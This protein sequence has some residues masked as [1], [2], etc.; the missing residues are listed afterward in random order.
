MYP[1]DSPLRLSRTLLA[2]L[3]LLLPRCLLGDV[4]PE[5]F[6]TD[7][8]ATL[9]LL[10][11]T[12]ATLPLRPDIP[13]QSLGLAGGGDCL[14]LRDASLSV[15]DDPGCLGVELTAQLKIGDGNRLSKTFTVLA[16]PFDRIEASDPSLVIKNA[17][18]SKIPLVGRRK[19]GPP[20]KL[21]QF[22]SH[23]GPL[24]ERYSVVDGKVLYRIDAEAYRGI[25]TQRFEVTA[26]G[27][28][29]SFSIDL[30][31]NIQELKRGGDAK[32]AQGGLYAVGPLLSALDWKGRP[33]PDFWKAYQ[34]KCSSDARGA[35]EE[36]TG[37]QQLTVAPHAT[38]LV[39]TCRVGALPDLA[40]V[41]IAF[42]VEQV[43]ASI[44][45]EPNLSTLDLAPGKNALVRARLSDASSGSFDFSLIGP[46]SGVTLTPASDS[47]VLSA[48]R[49]P[50]TAGVE[51]PS[52]SVY[53][54]VSERSGRAKPV[55]LEV[56]LLPPI[57]GLKPVTIQID[58]MDDLT[59]SQL[60]GRPASDA[61][62]VGNVAITYNP[63]SEEN[64]ER[65]IQEDLMSSSAVVFSGSLK[66]GV[67][68]EKTWDRKRRSRKPVDF[69]GEDGEWIDTTVED[70]ALL[71]GSIAGPPDKARQGASAAAAP[72]PC[73]AALRFKP[74]SFESI[75]NTHDERD[76]TTTRSRVFKGLSLLGTAA[77][78][79]TSVAVPGPTS[80]VPMALDKFAN[81]LVP[82][83]EKVFPSARETQ[84]QNLISMLMKSIEE[85]PFGTTVMKKVFFPKSALS[86]LRTAYLFRIAQVCTQDFEVKVGIVR[87]AET[88]SSTKKAAIR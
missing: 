2:A 10:A 52:E 41:T 25:S 42:S 30:I 18:N 77:S 68:F 50:A 11:G 46:P 36:G 33:L 53:L 86:G 45:L 9:V 61:F 23:L 47:A 13:I 12:P 32:L 81:L 54:Q 28:P 14:Q 60:F 6:L 16:L 17:D 71:G 38:A 73:A 39:L 43:S 75:V 88:V 57:G 1:F 40:P 19:D 78:F 37:G 48:P 27:N 3:L 56:R 4:T 87:N 21:D 24:N 34:L 70:V 15:K 44:S 79:V 5:P 66:V 31:S 85:V 64:W 29:L 59:V 67:T 58:I 35:V 26:G 84:R 83:L 82:G 62:V 55:H 76:A 72:G 49:R 80:D 65:C 7:G 63:C 69:S 22:V 74:Y 51:T 20:V 8:S